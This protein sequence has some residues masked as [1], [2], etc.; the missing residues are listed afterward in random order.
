MWSLYFQ[1]ASSPEDILI[2]TANRQYLFDSPHF[3]TAKALNVAIPGGPKFEPLF[4]DDFAKDEE[5]WNEFNDVNKIIIRHPIRTEYRI[6]FPQ[7]YNSRPR[8]V[9]MAPY[10]YPMAC[11]VP[12]DYG[13]GGELNEDDDDAIGMNKGYMFF[14][15]LHPIRRIHNVVNHP[16]RDDDDDFDED[17]FNQVQ[18]LVGDDGEDCEDYDRTYEPWYAE[19]ESNAFQR[20]LLSPEIV[21]LL[22]DTPLYTSKTRAGLTLYH[23]PGPFQLRQGRMRR[24]LDVPLVQH[25]YKER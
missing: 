8:K 21:P 23:A 3:K 2:D 12:A 24:A 10:C 19:E 16:M 11:V 6:A 25:W 7:L 9:V 18:P 14:P 13:M 15:T 4:K 5:D 17:E 22:S 20:R 1:S